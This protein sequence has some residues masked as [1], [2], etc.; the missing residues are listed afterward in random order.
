MPRKTVKG[1][2]YSA[3]AVKIIIL[4]FNFL[5]QINFPENL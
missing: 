3:T 4:N 1:K 2:R 5:V